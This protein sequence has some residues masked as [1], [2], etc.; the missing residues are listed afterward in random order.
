MCLAIPARLVELLPG[1]KAIVNLGGIRKTISVALID[2]ARVDDYVIVH[3]GHA[4]GKI[5]PEEAALTLAMFG[6]LMQ[7][8][9][10]DVSPTQKA[11]A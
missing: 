4:I 5:D 11:P 3:V 1:E 2:D 7:A 6:E 10:N 8:E 9:A